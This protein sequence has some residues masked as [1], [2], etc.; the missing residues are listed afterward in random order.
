MLP[1]LECGAVPL[2]LIDRAGDFQQFELA[3]KQWIR[4]EPIYRLSESHNSRM[5]FSCCQV[6]TEQLR[7][8]TGVATPLRVGAW[9]LPEHL[10]GMP[11]TR[12]RRLGSR[13]RLAL[14]SLFPS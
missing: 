2:V 9:V 4:E 11:A 7:T 12:Q 8:H 10:I 3:A 1:P 6:L 14:V 5:R 13:F